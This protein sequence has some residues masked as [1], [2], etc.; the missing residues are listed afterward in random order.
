[1]SRR[2]GWLYT[3]QSDDHVYA[4]GFLLC[5]WLRAARVP[6]AFPLDQVATISHKHT[7]TFLL[8]DSLLCP[9]NHTHAIVMFCRECLSLCLRRPLI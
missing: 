1:M 3:I 6:P 5:L 8:S 9:H 4:H 7:H 2:Q